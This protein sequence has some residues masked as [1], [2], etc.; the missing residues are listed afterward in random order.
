[1][2]ATAEE[3]RAEMARRGVLRYRVAS[4]VGIHPARLG[5]MLNE[6]IPMPPQVAEHISVAIQAEAPARRRERP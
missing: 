6:R 2:A 1:M 5:Q 3:L 4:R